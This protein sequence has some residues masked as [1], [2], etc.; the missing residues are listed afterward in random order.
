MPIFIPLMCLLVMGLVR[1]SSSAGAAPAGA[2]VR[3]DVPVRLLRWGSGLLSAQRE[4]WG[5]AMLGELDHIS[6]QG[7][8]WRFAI[9]CVSSILL[10]PPWGRAAAAIWALV[11]V[12]AGAE[13]LYVTTSV[14]YGLGVGDWVGA[15]IA[16]VLMIGYTLAASLVLRRPGVSLPGLVC[17]LCVA[18]A[19]VAVSGFTFYNF[20]APEPFWSFMALMF[21]VPLLA[22]TAGTL[23]GGSAVAGRRIARLAGYSAGLGVFLYGTLAAAVLGPGGPPD[24]GGGTTSFIIGDRLGNNTVFYLWLLPVTTAALGW[25]AAAATARL[26]PGLAAAAPPPL[27]VVRPCGA[28]SHQPPFE[29]QAVGPLVQATRRPGTVRLLLPYAVLAV[30]LIL[31]AVSFLRG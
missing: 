9:G 20:F 3:D 11:A 16:L 17:G 5:W 18:V 4:E 29:P 7:R 22:G 14:R 12:A 13:G 10:L 31:V 26:L 25:A 27:T 15:A 30:I 8:R 2:A 23:W 1:F 24:D 21:V 19:W 6:G 28:A